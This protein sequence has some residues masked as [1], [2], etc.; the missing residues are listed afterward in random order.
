MKPGNFKVLSEKEL[1]LIHA[2]SLRI[3]EESGVRV[4]HRRGIDLLEKIGCRVDRTSGT[5]KI[6]STVVQD[7]L[8]KV[9]G[10]F[11]LYGRNTDFRLD[12]GE[13]NVCFGPGGFAVFVED[14]KSG[15]RRRAV[16]RDLVEH[17]KVSDSLKGCEFNHVNV[18]PSDIP[19]KTADLHLWADAF[20]YQ[21][22]PI[23][24]ENYNIRSVDAL[25]EMG[26]VIRGSKKS[27]IDKPMV[28]LDV[29]VLSPLTHAERQ[30][31]LLLSG[32][33]YGLPISINSG[34]IAG[35][36]SPVTLASVVTQANAEI[37]SAI[38]IAYSAGP[39]APVLYSSW[40]RH[41]D[42]RTCAVTMGGP[43][44]ALLKI[45]TSQ[46]GKYYGIPTRGG[47]AL[48]D[49]LVSDAQAGYEKMLTTL[50]PAL[51]S[52]NYISGMGLNETENLQSLP[53][54]VIDNE[55]VM[56][57][58]RVLE[59]IKVD[60]EHLA[61]DLIIKKGPGSHFLDTEHT[62]TFFREELFSPELSNRASHEKWTERGSLSVD[63]RAA[64]LTRELL[65]NKP[66]SELDR[67][68]IAKISKIV[69]SAE[70]MI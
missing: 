47:G 48:S 51:G 6:P 28:C 60:P 34:P 7:T 16:R 53:Q 38:V 43:E 3:L 68:T 39:T 22:K 30:V 11:S 21:T 12:L 2:E 50:M 14:L 10:I 20:V 64:Q 42:M 17:L 49:S 26:A 61:V 8:D 57:V 45:C 23:M 4:H 19:E 62:L 70:E 44:F 9:P 27:L 67:R 58:K 46:M 40:G 1:E 15:E 69:E 33:E 56:M 35:A 63:R 59:G 13:D 52:M 55:I 66:E 31:D 25:V 37:I 65:E 18:F 24:S 36:T 32:A 29:C 5:V 41:M 54:L